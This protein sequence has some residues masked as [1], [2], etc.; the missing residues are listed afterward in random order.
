MD[1]F[2]I[3]P[4]WENYIK[5]WDPN[6]SLDQCTTLLWELTCFPFGSKE[7][8]EEQIDEVMT[9]LKTGKTFMDLY[10]ERDNE[11]TNELKKY[12]ENDNV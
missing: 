2:V 3:R 5:G 11:I 6:I 9:S 8:V 12:K 4:T 7:Q 10:E 1:S